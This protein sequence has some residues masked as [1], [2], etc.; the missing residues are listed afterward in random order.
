LYGGV[1]LL[2]VLVVLGAF[3]LLTGRPEAIDSIAVLPFENLTGDAGQEYF[4]DGIT[5][6]LIARLGSI[7]AF[8]RVIS[9]WSVMRYKDTEKSLKE[10]A[11]DLNVGAVV[12]GSVRQA[13]DRVNIQVSLVDVLPEEQSLWEET[14]DRHM[15]DVLVMYSDIA[16]SIASEIKIKL[17]PDE[18]TLLD[19]TREVNPETYEAYLKGMS[20]LNKG[21]PEEFQKGMAYFQEAVEKN[22]EDPLAYA[23]LAFGY[24]TLGHN[25]MGPG[26]AW[27]RA[28]AAADSALRLDPTLAEARA[29]LADCKLYGEWD[30]EGAEQ[31]FLRVNELNPNLAMNHYHHAWYLALMG[32]LDEAIEVHKRAQELDPLEPL[33]TAWLGWLYYWDGEFEKA[34]EE[35]KKAI[36]VNSSYPTAH[37]ILAEIYAEKG[38]HEEAIAS[39]QKAAEL[40]PPIFG[41]AVGRIYA[42]I[43]QTEEARKILSEWETQEVTPWATLTMAALNGILGEMDEAFRWLE[44]GYEIRTAW[45]PWIRTEALFEPHRKD[46]RIHELIE[47]M[48]LPPID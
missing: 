47:R 20:F 10:I 13:G 9:H 5:N 24:V 25:P 2:L 4:A 44:K 11:Q 18:D 21:T 37:W 46:P 19:S 39:V 26:D 12:A 31:G 42:R 7:G 17:S 34:M 33:H 35:A 3:Y 29:A 43:G 40:A 36:E 23:G 38:M 14:F 6:E 27:P 15:T 41:W 32:R 22:P 8:Q 30:W 1:P 48:N 16:R 28:R 45:L